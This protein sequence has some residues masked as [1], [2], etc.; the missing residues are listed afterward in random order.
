MIIKISQF[1][2]FIWFVASS[3][4][5]ACILSARKGFG[6]LTT[7]V[8]CLDVKITMTPCHGSA[9]RIIGP[10]HQTS[11][12]PILR[13]SSVELYIASLNQVLNKQS[14]CRY[15]SCDF[16]VMSWKIMLPGRV[17]K[18]ISHGICT[19]IFVLVFVIESSPHIY[20]WGRWTHI[21][22]GCFTG[23]VGQSYDYPSIL[24]KQMKSTRT[25]AQQ[26]TNFGSHEIWYGHRIVLKFG[27]RLGSS[28]A[29]FLNDKKI[30]SPNI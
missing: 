12:S 9:F 21:L 30:Q 10:F 15:S 19:R 3:K 1:L 29:K 11:G 7:R 8:S 26:N 25:K 4:L 13:A 24:K 2:L 20:S 23:T 28:A 18:N 22:Q 5:P 27:R 6:P 14:S 17:G 16:N